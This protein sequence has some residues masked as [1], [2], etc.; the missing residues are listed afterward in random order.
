MMKFVF[1]LL[2]ALAFAPAAY[3]QDGMNILRLSR[4]P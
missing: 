1:I 3:A 2:I 4:K